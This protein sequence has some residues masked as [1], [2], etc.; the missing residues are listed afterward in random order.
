MWLLTASYDKA[1]LFDVSLT[2]INFAGLFFSEFF[3]AEF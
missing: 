1:E 2:F 3:F